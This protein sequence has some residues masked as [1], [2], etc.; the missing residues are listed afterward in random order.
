MKRAFAVAACAAAA[1]VAPAAGATPLG[2]LGARTIPRAPAFAPLDLALPARE[3]WATYGGDYGHRRYSSLDDIK[4]SNVGSLV[5]V[6]H[7]HLQSAQGARY[8]GEATPIV[9]QGVMYLVTGSDD[10]FALDAVTG[11]LLWTYGTRLPSGLSAFVCCGWAQRGVALGDGKVFVAQLDNTVVA[12]SQSDGHVLWQA[13]NAR[14]RDG[15]T[16]TMAPLYY[17]GLVIV[18]SSGGEFGVRGSV[19]AYD[20][21]SGRLVWRFYTVP[22]PGQ[23]G[24][25]TWP[26]GNE[27]LTGGATVWN[28][29][30]ADPRTGLLYFTTGNAYP[31]SNRGAGDDLF[32]SSF[33]ALDA[34]TGAYAWHFQVVHHDIWDYDCP[35][36]TVLFD[37]RIGGVLRNVVAEPCKTGW[38]Y[39]LDRAR[40]T[41]VLPI[42]EKPVPQSEY[43]HTSPTQPFPA[44]EGFARQCADRKAFPKRAPDGKPFRFGC[45]FTPFDDSRFTALA[46]GAGGGS[47]WNPSAYSPNTGYLYVCSR[48]SEFGYKA[49]PRISDVTAGGTSAVGAQ[50]SYSTSKAATS[51][52]LTALDMGTNRIV[53]RRI[54]T[55]RTGQTDAAC[56]SGALATAGGLVFL[57]LP[58][59]V[60]RGLAAFDAKS[61]ARL[62]RFR[63]DA[64]V[65]APPVTYSVGGKQ[66]LA[67]YAGGR[68][69]NASGVRGDSV[70][71]FALPDRLRGTHGRVR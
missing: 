14:W 5:A 10:V 36:S 59:G 38:V 12:L 67:V 29:P 17:D 32:T 69:A 35:A 47:N 48:N 66:Y 24:A 4:R 28:T 16:T 11:Q 27:W 13:S 42:V 71:V 8:K 37:K 31:W 52:A 23:L 2:K 56:D 51:G 19:T 15:Y 55:R 45:I 20:A 40:G 3:D 58:A 57:G 41:P 21:N 44:G 39:E 49:V 25:N 30:S 34:H 63:T 18:G 50:L 46:P 9:Y 70:Y 54:F 6:A 62:W 26:A 43:Q 68:T 33:V 1:S 53:W 60:Y 22:A 64:G 65:E 7:V 61:G